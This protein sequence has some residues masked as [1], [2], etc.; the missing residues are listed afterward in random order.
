MQAKSGSDWQAAASCCLSTLTFTGGQTKFFGFPSDAISIVLERAVAG[1]GGSGDNQLSEGFTFV[2]KGGAG[3]GAQAAYNVFLPN[4]YAGGNF[5]VTLSGTSF[6]NGGNLVFTNLDNN[7]ILL[8]LEGGKRGQDALNKGGDGGN[9]GGGTLGGDGRANGGQSGQ[10][11][12]PI[13][14]T[15]YNGGGGGGGATVGFLGGKGGD[16][17]TPAAL[18]TALGGSNRLSVPGGGASAFGA[19]AYI[20]T[21]LNSIAPG[22]GAGTGEGSIGRPGG[23]ALFVVTYCSACG[24][25][26]VGV[27][28]ACDDGNAIDGDNC[29][30]ACQIECTVDAD[31][32]GVCS[33]GT[34]A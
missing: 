29:N 20:D 15:I 33:G 16:V 32:P 18:A 3:G 27:G 21:N 8:T 26:V 12:G 6:G 5:S 1:G 9:G 13:S 7:L 25:G 14:S 2:Y 19:G 31:C 10:D 11:G 22:F 34:C 23:R 24:D 28:E 17:L 4:S 30:S